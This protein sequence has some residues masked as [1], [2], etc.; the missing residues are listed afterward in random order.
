MLWQGVTLHVNTVEATVCELDILGE[1]LHKGIFH[2]RLLPIGHF[3]VEHF[4]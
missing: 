3:L 4:I 1:L 2:G